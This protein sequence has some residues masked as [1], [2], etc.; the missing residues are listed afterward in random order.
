MFGKKKKLRKDLPA[1]DIR[2]KPVKKLFGGTKWV[3]ASKREQRAVK[4]QLMERYPDRYFV[5]DLA[6]WNSISGK[7]IDLAWID[8]IEELDALLLD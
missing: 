3:P 1:I 7:E 2:T 5:D 6:E 4:K 8:E